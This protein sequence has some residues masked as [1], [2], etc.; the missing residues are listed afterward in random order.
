[1]LFV[2]QDKRA[3]FHTPVF[4]PLLGNPF[5]HSEILHILKVFNYLLMV[6]NTVYD[7]NVFKSFQSFT[8]EFIALKTASDALFS[9][10]ITE[11]MLTVPAVRRQFIGQAAFAVNRILRTCFAKQATDCSCPSGTTRSHGAFLR[12]TLK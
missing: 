1:M 12:I 6:G 9:G 5:L 11:P 2:P 3:A 4:L 7:M 8:R 10:T